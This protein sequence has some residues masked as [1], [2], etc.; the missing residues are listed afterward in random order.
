MLKY[1]GIG[2][3]GALIAG[4][5]A[6]VQVKKVFSFSEGSDIMKKI[7]EEAAEGDEDAQAILKLLK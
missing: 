4:L 6:F 2:F 5:F 7:R 1:F 3:V